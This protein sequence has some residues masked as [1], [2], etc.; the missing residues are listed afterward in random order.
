MNQL[1]APGGPT[2][3]RTL[4]AALVVLFAAAAAGQD[5][6]TTA[7]AAPGLRV[8]PAGTIE[9]HVV[10]LPLPDV[11]RMLAEQTRRNV[12]ISKDASATITADLYDVTL[13]EALDAILTANGLGY[14]QDGNFLYIHTQ[15][16]LAAMARAARQPVTRVFPLHYVTAKEA[17]DV[18]KPVLSDIGKISITSASDSGIDPDAETSGDRLSGQ[19]VIVLLDYPENVAAA[20]RVL[21]QLDVRPRQVLVEATIL[22]AGLEE[23][24]AL[25]IDFNILGG[26]NFEGLNTVSPAVTAAQPGNLPPDMM[27]KSNYTLRTDFMAGFPAGGMTFGLIKNHVAFFLRALEQVTDVTVLANPKVLALNKQQGRVIVGR[28]DGYITTTVTETTATQTV[29]FLETGMQLSF[30]PFIGDDGY[31]RMEI[32]PKDSIGGLTAANLPQEQTTEVTSNILVK[33][34]HTILIGGLFRE[35]TRTTRGQVPLVGNVPIAGALFRTTRD[36]AER[37]EVIILLTVHIIKSAEAEDAMAREMAEHIEQI[38]VGQRTGA[39]WFGRERL[40]QA[41]YRQAL[42]DA[43]AGR[44]SEALWHVRLALHNNP[45]FTVAARL[46]AKLLGRRAWDEDSTRAR[47]YAVREFLRESGLPDEPKYARPAPPFELPP[48]LHRPPATQPAAAWPA[49]PREDQP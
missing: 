29:E 13:A 35:V 46:R 25:G 32:Q 44:L 38:R 47:D 14:R 21:G 19:D 22:R 12:I 1:R 20:E 4:G 11:L 37:E 18:L 28:R 10:N 45:R 30:R 3:V 17:G 23:D 27:Q 39:Q 42:R 41:H 49:A 43:S 34:G 24:N 16:E 2:A 7:P 9:L 33:D 8:G 26:V 31:V 15:E 6:P 5:P 36:D 40:A 48:T